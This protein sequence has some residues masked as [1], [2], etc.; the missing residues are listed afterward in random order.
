MY[1]QDALS[2][3]KSAPSRRWQELSVRER[4]ALVLLLAPLLQKL[5]SGLSRRKRKN[6]K[7]LSGAS[8]SK[9][10]GSTHDHA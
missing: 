4:V 6:R 1:D 5:D 2:M 10:A 8:K 9:Q 7:H 3:M